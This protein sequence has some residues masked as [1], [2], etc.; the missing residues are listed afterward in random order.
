VLC[1]VRPSYSPSDGSGAANFNQLLGLLDGLVVEG[2][3]SRARDTPPGTP[4]PAGSAQ[5][6]EQ[7]ERSTVRLF[8][9]SIADW[10]KA[11]GDRGALYLHIGAEKSV[12][13][14]ALGVWRLRQLAVCV[15][16]EQ[17]EMLR[18]SIA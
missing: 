3:T 9:Q 4:D 13:Q 14:L 7:G 2:E 16:P 17:L 5:V 6:R 1:G 15:S 10:L 18:Q 8:H 11:P 12:G